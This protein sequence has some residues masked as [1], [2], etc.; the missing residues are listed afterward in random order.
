MMFL[1]SS[2]TC[3]GEQ[4]HKNIDRKKKIVDTVGVY[5]TTIGGRSH[6]SPDILTLHVSWGPWRNHW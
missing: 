4:D 2:A 3:A 6:L 5:F 1:L